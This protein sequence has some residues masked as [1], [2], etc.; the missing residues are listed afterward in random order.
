MKDEQTQRSKSILVVEDHYESA[1][2]IRMI[3]EERGYQVLCVE[4]GRE[5]L[6]L[7]S[8]ASMDANPEFHADLILLDLRLPDMDG[9]EVVRELRKNKPMIPPIVFLSANPLQ[10]LKDAADSVGAASLRKPFD[11]DELYRVIEKAFAKTASA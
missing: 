10:S 11:F 4:T 1:E 9:V 5:A 8:P 2:L 7:S 6:Q 3:L